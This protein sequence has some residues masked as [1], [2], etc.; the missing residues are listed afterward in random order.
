M[1]RITIKFI[2]LS[3]I[4][5]SDLTA[6]VYGGKNF[7]RVVANWKLFLLELKVN[8]MSVSILH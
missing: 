6:D 4:L 7:L 5:L 8:V 3:T 2:E 1:H